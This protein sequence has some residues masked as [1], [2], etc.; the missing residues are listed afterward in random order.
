M[1]DMIGSVPPS[2][3]TSDRM[4]LLRALARLLDPT[5]TA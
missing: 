2:A 5:A 1:T 3:A 4:S